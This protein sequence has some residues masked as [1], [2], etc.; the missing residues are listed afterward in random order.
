MLPLRA[1]ETTVAATAEG[2]R[3]RRRDRA[4]PTL[5]CPRDRTVATSTD[6]LDAFFPSL[7]RQ[8]SLPLCFFF[9]LSFHFSFFFLCHSEAKTVRKDTPE[10]RAEVIDVPL[11]EACWTRAISHFDS[12]V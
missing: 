3:A 9:F 5:A 8:A 1:L 6:R 2:G 11:S 10:K 7:L 4:G 12:S